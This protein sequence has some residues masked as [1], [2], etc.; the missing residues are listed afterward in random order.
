M[1][2]LL[3]LYDFEFVAF[4][5]P[6]GTKDRFEENLKTFFESCDWDYKLS[7]LGGMI[8]TCGYIQGRKRPVTEDDRHLLARWAKAQRVRCVAR[9]GAL[10]EY[11]K[12]TDF[13]RDVTEWVFPVDNLDES[14]RTEAAK[15]QQWIRDL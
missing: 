12:E 5:N 6:S 13:F 14:D 2:Q 7:A 1:S 4:E 3:F 10:E 15:Y 9:L 11:S 8:H